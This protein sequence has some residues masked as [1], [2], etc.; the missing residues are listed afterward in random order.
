MISLNDKE[1]S[2]QNMEQQKCEE[3]WKEL[4][5]N[6]T[7]KACKTRIFIAITIFE[8]EKKYVKM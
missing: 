3:K 7:G 8:G 5:W 2:I 6:L 4:I 1:N